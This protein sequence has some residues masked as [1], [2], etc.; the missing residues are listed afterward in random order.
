M[1]QLMVEQF[2]DMTTSASNVWAACLFDPRF[3]DLSSFG[4]SDDVQR[5]VWNLVE[6]EHLGFKTSRARVQKG[7]DKYELPSGHVALAKAHLV[8]LQE[9]MP[10]RSKE[11]LQKLSAGS[12]KIGDMDPLDFWRTQAG[13]G[14]LD[15]NLSHYTALAATACM[16]LSA[17]ANTATSERGVG[18]LRRT[19]TPFRNMLSE[20]MLEQEVICSHFIN[21]PLYSF[22]RVCATVAQLQQE[23]QK[24]K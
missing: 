17:P 8:M 15:D 22:V 1:K 12:V 23:A 16:M 18:R 11:F 5:E 2:G 6:I 24:S 14:T 7:D 21:G 10:K 19:A 4:V 3:A 13:L 9:E 20:G